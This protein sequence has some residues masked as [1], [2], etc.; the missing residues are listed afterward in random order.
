MNPNDRNDDNNRD[1]LNIEPDFLFALKFKPAQY[2]IINDGGFFTA[3]A[4]RQAQ[5]RVIKA[6]FSATKSIAFRCFSTQN[7]PKNGQAIGASEIRN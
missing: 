7:V 3:P 2:C 1:R 4:A 5:P 6:P